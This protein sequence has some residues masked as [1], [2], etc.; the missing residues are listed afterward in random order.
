[1]QT[2]RQIEAE[3]GNIYRSLVGDSLT[4]HHYHVLVGLMHRSDGLFIW[5]GTPDNIFHISLNPGHPLAI[6]LLNAARVSHDRAYQ[7]LVNF[8][9]DHHTLSRA[10][11]DETFKGVIGYVPYPERT[12]ENLKI[13]WVAE[14]TKWWNIWKNERFAMGVGFNTGQ[15]L[16][17]GRPVEAEKSVLV[18]NVGPHWSE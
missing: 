8:Y 3:K 14:E 6:P 10:E 9:R 15:L 16:K 2:R 17:S 5:S 18:F 13:K 7:P 12:E 11:L 4:E 1:M